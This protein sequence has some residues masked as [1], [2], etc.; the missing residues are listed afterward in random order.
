MF[1]CIKC[2]ADTD[3]DSDWCDDCIAESRKCPKCGGDFRMVWIGNDPL[4][5]YGEVCDCP[6]AQYD[7]GQAQ[8]EK[9]AQEWDMRR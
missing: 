6:D 8:S 7:L 9:R 2:S 1:T 3:N 5:P 4:E